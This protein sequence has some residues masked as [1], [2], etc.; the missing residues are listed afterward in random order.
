M[1]IVESLSK[2]IIMSKPSVNQ[3]HANA[4]ASGGVLGIITYLLMKI[5]AD[6]AL[7]SMALPLIAAVLSWVSTRIGDPEVA[8]FIGTNAA[9]DGKPVKVAA[10][11]KPVKKAAPK[12]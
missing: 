9:D 5:D 7:V 3:F 12:K 1:Q 6:P 8:S 11:K 2:G 10:K 4:A